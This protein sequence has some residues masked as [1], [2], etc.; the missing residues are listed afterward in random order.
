MNQSQFAS[1]LTIKQTIKEIVALKTTSNQKG[2]VAALFLERKMA[3]THKE[4][5]FVPSQQTSAGVSCAALHQC[6]QYVAN[7]I[8]CFDYSLSLSHQAV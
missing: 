2:D 1:N 3:P 4:K 6:T 5:Q 8:P 7:S